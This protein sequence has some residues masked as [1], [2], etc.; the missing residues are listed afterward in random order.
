MQI[1]NKDDIFFQIFDE[2]LIKQ[3]D[4]IEVLEYQV[5]AYKDVIKKLKVKIKELEEKEKTDDVHTGLQE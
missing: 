5:K 2:I 3:R 1:T 4:R